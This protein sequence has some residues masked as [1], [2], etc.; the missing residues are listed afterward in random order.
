MDALYTIDEIIKATGGCAKNITAKNISSITIDSREV[1][2]G[3]LFVAIKGNRFDGHD[4]VQQAIK[5]GATAAL[6]SEKFAKDFSDL[7]T[8]IVP[9]AL[10]GLE[11]LARYARERTK[12]KIIA[13][14]GSAGKTSTKEILREVLSN[15]GKTHASI[16]SFNNHWGV[17]LMLA[18]MAKDTDYAI[19]EIGMNN[20]GEILALSKMVKPDIAII[21]NIAPAH[22][23][24]L[25]SLE[26]IALAKSEIFVGLKKSGTAIINIDN[27][28]KEILLTQAKDNKIKNIITYGFAK[29]AM[30]HIENIK[31]NPDKIS[32]KLNFD[33]QLIDFEILGAGK[34]KLANATCAIIVAK[35]LGL[36]IEQTVKTIAKYEDIK[37][38]GARYYFG[39]KN[40]LL[41]IDESY[42]AN[43]L[44]MRVALEAFAKIKANNGK[45][46]LV[47]G[48]MLELGEQAKKLHEDLAPIILSVRA[49]KIYLVGDNMRFLANKIS[50]TKAACHA[51][52]IIN[53]E[54][55]I[56]NSLD[57][58]DVIMVKG[59]NGIMLSNLVAKI[60][61]R[62]SGRE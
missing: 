45:K 26:N 51:K 16:K 36:E 48:D 10:K 32:A 58:G 55:K 7:P 2:E 13:V 53:I 59:S 57:F 49:D 21:T 40:P 29:E 42:N 60:I 33:K 17:P 61:K 50:P 44:S 47:L 24:Q 39:E 19:F 41:L 4:F 62:F 30:A 8:I 15:F 28:Q 20:R 1:K 5:E 37:G 38:R 35:L 12:A 14:T 34:H 56:L 54:E 52:N 31:E 18:R 11:K 6:I 23:E 46:I 22:L 43:P 25:G 3:A 9:D 27:L